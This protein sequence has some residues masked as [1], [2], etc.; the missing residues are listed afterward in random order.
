MPG[1]SFGNLFK[2]TTWG[3]SHGRALGVVIDGCPPGLE[4]TE[5]EVQLE[6]NRRRPGNE[7][8]SGREERDRVEIL[9]GLFEGRTLGTPISMMVRNI[10]A[11][12]EDYAEIKEIYRP[13]HADY[14]YE[15]KYGVRDW[16]GGGRSSGRE[17]LGRVAAGAIARKIL[18]REGV[19][20]R[21]Y[22]KQVGDLEVNRIDLSEIR[23]N[24]V[25]CPDR[26]M[27]ERF[28]DEIIRMQM[29]GDSIGGVVEL[30]ACDV[31]VGLGEPV[32]D[33][34]EAD[35]A[36]AMMSIGG[37]RGVEFG[38]G[39]Q[40]ARMRG[41]ESNDAMVLRN[42]RVSTRTNKGGGVSGG[43]SNGEDIVLR[44]A[45]KP[46]A[47]ILKKQKTVNRQGQEVEVEVGGR[48]DPCIAL[49]IV[50]VA[51]SMA[52]LV[53]VDQLMRL[54]ALRRAFAKERQGTA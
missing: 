8:V 3:E 15:A 38:S 10:N 52:M 46:T 45:V 18:Y 54:R 13:G 21:G 47:S 30:I 34:L 11:R 32:F 20:V 12:S 51:E 27:A 5:G 37:V 40:L 9:S 28:R 19:V 14:S 22:V 43:I 25:F 31:P 17:T 44:L 1:N 29:E 49:R 33:K 7:L 50:P 23:N 48:H 16:R 24:D 41:S 26:E 42:G 6:L 53:L 4:L 36:K 39:F 2:V 35:L